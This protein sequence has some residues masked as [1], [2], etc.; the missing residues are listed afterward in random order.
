MFD[1]GSVDSDPV[2]MRYDLPSGAGRLFADSVGMKHVLV[3]GRAIVRGGTL[4]A[5]RPGT[6]LRS[7][8]DTTSAVMS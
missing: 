3:N 8:R 2:A 5:D 1:P 4:T 6:V 7:G